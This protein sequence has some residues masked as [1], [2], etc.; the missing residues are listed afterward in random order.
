[1]TCRQ[2]WGRLLIVLW[3][4]SRALSSC[5]QPA[6]EALTEQR[7]C[8]LPERWHGCEVLGERAAPLDAAGHTLTPPASPGRLQACCTQL[9]GAAD[10]GRG[11]ASRGSISACMF[12]RRPRRRRLAGASPTS[13]CTALS[14]LPHFNI[15]VTAL[16]TT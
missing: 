16:T 12:G 1:M 6:A 7:H 5:E 10:D 2:V 14:T 8:E 9:Q 11:T 15:G 4:S 13:N 3:E